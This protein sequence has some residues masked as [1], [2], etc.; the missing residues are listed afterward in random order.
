MNNDKLEDKVSGHYP[1]FILT[2]NINTGDLKKSNIG[3]YPKPIEIDA[4]EFKVILIGSPIIKNIINKKDVVNKILSRG[5]LDPNY[6]ETI[7]GEFLIILID[8][9]KNTLSVTNDRFSSIQLYY[10]QTKKEVILSFAYL[11]IL[12]IAKN[13]L[14]FRMRGDIVFEYLWFRRVYG[15]STYD[16]LIKFMK[17]ARI[18][19]FSNKGKDEIVYYMPNFNKNS[20]SLSQNS[21]IL[22]NNISKSITRKLSDANNRK[23]GLFLSGGMDTRVVLS[24]LNKTDYI[25]QLQY[26]TLGYSKS[27]EY[28][29]A[30]Q[31]TKTHRSNHHFVKLPH[32]Y[33]DKYWRDKL[34]ISGGLFNQYSIIF[35][36]HSD[37]IS[38]HANLFFHGHGLDYMFQGMYLP[39][40]TMRLF[41]KNTYF[42][43]ID[44]LNNLS[45][46]ASYFSNNSPYRAW[47][48][49]VADYVKPKYKDEILEGLHS[50]I[51]SIVDEGR[52][53]CNDNYDLWEYMLIHTPS[54]HYSQTDVTGISTNGEQRKIANDNDLFNF[55]TSLPIKH[56]MYARVMRGALKKLSPEFS[57][58]ISANTGYK[59]NASPASL[60]TH[61]MGYKLLRT[62]TGNQ[63]FSHPKAN[64][65]TWPDIDNEVRIRSRLRKDIIKLHNSEHLRDLLPFFDFNKLER[66]THQ[67]I[68]KGR[69]GGGLFLTSLLT[70]DNMM[71]E[72]S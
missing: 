57:R 30:K 32:D 61:F 66:D 24:A 52:S 53:V 3:I 16:S 45:N 28:R 48:V 36:G 19:I 13:E 29:V 44:N 7:N 40:S 49:N 65:R 26:F 37:L 31:L 60:T 43:T 59:I 34:Y 50:R 23:I 35:A 27:G 1:S 55:Y 25:D 54:R 11:D 51:E 18:L 15:E 42:K 72:I 21:Q 14:D 46:F 69:P 10:Y 5:K 12:K 58:I 8:K 63:K 67:W 62:I 64:S 56:R 39:T 71:K 22:A 17:P 6:I 9:K 20:N 33:Y 47:R 4:Q 41:G 38:S 70:I 68:N 2:Y